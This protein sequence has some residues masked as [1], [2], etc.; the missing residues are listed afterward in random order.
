MPQHP[1]VT[2]DITVDVTRDGFL[3]ARSLEHIG[4]GPWWQYIATANSLDVAIAIA[5]Q[6]AAAANV[7]AWFRPNEAGDYTEIVIRPTHDSL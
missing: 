3:I 2:G 7:R 4:A 5:R 6:L 1:P